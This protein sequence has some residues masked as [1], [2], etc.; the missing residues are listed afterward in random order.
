MHTNTIKE[1][2]EA[3][4]LHINYSGHPS[5]GRYLQIMDRLA[6]NYKGAPAFKVSSLLDDY[7]KSVDVVNLKQAIDRLKLKEKIS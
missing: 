7:F 6:C 1:I 3:L 5:G 2:E 4:K